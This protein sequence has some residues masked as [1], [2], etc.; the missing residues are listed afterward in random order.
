MNA[1]ASAFPR[2]SASAA[3]VTDDP[4][5]AWV[6]VVTSAGKERLAKF[7]LQKQGFE[8]YLPM[9][10]GQG[11]AA[12]RPF[13]P[14]Y[15]FA[16]VTADVRRW[17]SIFSTIGVQR[18]FTNRERIVGVR[19][20]FIESIRAQEAD[21]LLKAGVGVEVVCPFVE[22]DQVLMGALTGIFQER[23]D[24]RRALIL[25]QLLGKANAITVDLSK[26]E[27]SEPGGTTSTHAQHRRSA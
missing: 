11:A 25:V 15:L 19:D 2:R 1:P 7:H 3:V 16:R 27:A 17:Q 6:V 5:Q 9:K 18:V 22:G 10:L 20:A 8:V 23:V 21:G 12:V 14:R 24:D 13:F 4:R 26:L